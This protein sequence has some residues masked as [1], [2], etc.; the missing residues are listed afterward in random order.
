MASLEIEGVEQ[1]IDLQDKTEY[2]LGRTDAASHSHPDIDLN[3][4]DASEAG[5]SRRHAKITRLGEDR[6]YMMDL[7]STN[8][9]FVNGEKLEPF[10][11]RVLS[12]GDEILLG[13]FKMFFREA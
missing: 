3:P 10:E 8:S 4:F 7:S 13:T 11:P 2:T 12:D 6:Y 5:V 1:A 9:T